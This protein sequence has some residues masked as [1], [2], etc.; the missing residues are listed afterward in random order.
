MRGGSLVARAGISVE[1]KAE[2]AA[3]KSCAAEGGGGAVKTDGREAKKTQD[4]IRITLFCFFASASRS[5]QEDT[6][7]RGQQRPPIQYI[8]SCD[9]LG[10]FC[11]YFVFR[12]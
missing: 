4:R 7:Q 3:A 1:E 2:A 5:Q 12:V 6:S 10:V 11:Y 8:R 9:W